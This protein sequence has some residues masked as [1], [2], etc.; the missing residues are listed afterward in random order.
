MQPAIG[1]MIGGALIANRQLPLRVPSGLTR[2]LPEITGV[3]QLT[4]AEIG[5]CTSIAPER[6]GT[7]STAA[8]S[9]EFDQRIVADGIER[10][11]V[12]QRTKCAS[13]SKSFYKQTL[14]SGNPPLPTGQTGRQMP[15]DYPFTSN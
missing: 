2:L 13:V 11:I 9:R 6:S 10:S 5:S 7:S 14:S 12:V 8:Y 3:L 1:A 4:A 15:K